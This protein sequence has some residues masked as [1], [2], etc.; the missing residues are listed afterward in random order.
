MSPFER[1]G[2]ILLASAV[3]VLFISVFISMLAADPF[4]IGFIVAAGMG[5]VGLFFFMRGR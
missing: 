4:T 1:Q 2:R 5:V 3:G